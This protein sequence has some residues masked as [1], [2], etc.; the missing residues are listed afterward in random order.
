MVAACLVWLPYHREQQAIAELE[1]FVGVGALSGEIKIETISPSGVPNPKGE[2]FLQSFKRLSRADLSYAPIRDDDLRHF[3]GISN[4]QSL[5][6]YHTSVGDE[7]MKHLQQLTK[8]E[9]LSLEN[10]QVTNAGLEYLRGMKNLKLLYLQ[11]SHVT[12]EGIEKLEQALPDCEIFWGDSL[13]EEPTS[14]E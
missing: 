7:G 9:E 5:S 14:P 3:S 10:T 6:L 8:L 4:L 1:K 2:G 11:R 13:I 12:Q